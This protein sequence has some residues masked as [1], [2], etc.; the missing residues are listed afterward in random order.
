M[1]VTRA[2]SG[3]LS[4]TTS[5]PSGPSTTWSMPAAT[6]RPLRSVRWTS[7][8]EAGPRVPWSSLTSGASRTAATRGSL[9]GRG[10]GSLATSS[11]WT[12]MRAGSSIASTTY[13]M[14]ATARWVNDTNRTEVTRMDWP[15][16]ETHST[17]RC[18]VPA[19][20][21]RTRRW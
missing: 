18:S 2:M 1:I 14:A 12:T 19:R 3:P 7:V 17:V 20:K 15:A 21:S 8:A 10:I 11:D 9:S 4:L 5:M 16:G 13:S 6:R